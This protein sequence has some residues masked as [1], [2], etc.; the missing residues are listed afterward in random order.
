[1]SYMLDLYF[2]ALY[3]I[4]NYITAAYS[5]QE[6]WADDSHIDITNFTKT[7]EAAILL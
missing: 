5:S 3:S 6:L 2:C 7:S 4:M 1:M